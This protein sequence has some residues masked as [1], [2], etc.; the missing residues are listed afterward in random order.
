MSTF[1]TTTDYEASIHSEILDAII[2]NDDDILEIIEEQAISEMTGYLSARYN[3][4]DIF[5]KTGSARHSLILMFAKDITLYHLHSIH[6]PVKFP[7]IRKDRYDQA[8]EWL[9][10]VRDGE[11]NPTG[12]TLAANTDG[13]QGGQ[14]NYAF[15][16]NTKR[17]NHF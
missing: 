4:D 12:L 3:C 7:L 15:A 16:S 9:R 5:G 10:A 14:L 11:I 17:T 1:I 2:R 6:N 8:I 13:D